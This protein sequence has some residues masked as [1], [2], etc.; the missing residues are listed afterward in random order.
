MASIDV[1]ARN[2]HRVVGKLDDDQ[3]PRG[4]A[5]S[6]FFLIKTVIAAQLA[7][8]LSKSEVDARDDWYRFVLP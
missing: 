4:A 1:P 6:R 8:A 5:V 7:A 3:H 2:A